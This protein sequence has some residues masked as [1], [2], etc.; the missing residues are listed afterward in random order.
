MSW[1]YEYM[2]ELERNPT[3]LLK[4]ERQVAEELIRRYKLTR[5]PLKRIGAWFLQRRI[6]K[7]NQRIEQLS[8]KFDH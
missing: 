5:N 8:D 4:E 2:R 1:V 7:I 3:P 6:Q